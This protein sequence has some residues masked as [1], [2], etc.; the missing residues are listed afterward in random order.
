METKVGYFGQD[1][2]TFPTFTLVKNCDIY[3]RCWDIYSLL[4][5]IKTDVQMFPAV[6]L[7][8]YF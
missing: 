2:G 3:M 7:W 1:D 8:S 6:F 5:V 4:S